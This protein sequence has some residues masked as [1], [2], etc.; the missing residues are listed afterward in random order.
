METVAPDIVA[1][2]RQLSAIFPV[3]GLLIGLV[4]WLA[5]WWTHRFWVVLGMTVLGGIVGLHQ[6]AVLQTQ[7]LVAALGVGL[8]AGMLA[9]T[10]VRIGA[11][12][13]GGYAALLLVHAW[14]PSWDQPF[15]SFLAGGLLGWLLVR[16]WTMV[17]TSLTGVLLILYS[18]LAL[19]DKFG[20]LDAVLW[21]ERNAVTLNAVC[22]AMT[23]GGFLV[24]FVADWLRKRGAK[25]DKNNKKDGKDSKKQ[26]SGGVL[27]ALPAFRRAS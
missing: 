24:Q 22:A 1:D 8:A 23:L 14:S 5:G 7:P 3:L 6:A 17:L 11:F 16:Y 15:I 9:L 25:D 12:V 4:L 13:A 21:S 20:K 18:V 2:V 26:R 27:A 19:A 10:L